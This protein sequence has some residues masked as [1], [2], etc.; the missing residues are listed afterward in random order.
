MVY[1]CIDLYEYI[2]DS[3]KFWVIDV[4]RQQCSFVSYKV[5]VYLGFLTFITII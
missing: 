5:W 1:I 4:G 3:L 2:H